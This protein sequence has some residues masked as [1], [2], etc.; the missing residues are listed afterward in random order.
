M[1]CPEY[2]NF[3]MD[4]LNL[5]ANKDDYGSCWLQEPHGQPFE[6]LMTSHLLTCPR[7]MFA[8]PA[9]PLFDRLDCFFLGTASLCIYR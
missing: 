4:D 1:T 8:E 2:F 5:R 6:L 3:N 7:H 9:T